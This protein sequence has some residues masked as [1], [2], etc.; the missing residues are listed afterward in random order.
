MADKKTTTKPKAKAQTPTL[1]NNTRPSGKGFSASQKYQYHKK[2]ANTAF[3]KGDIVKS[4]NHLS[5]M[6]RAENT[7]RSQAKWAK[8][9]NPR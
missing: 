4:S 9:N 3:Q 7:L 1:T 8:E 2:E 6:R 5:A